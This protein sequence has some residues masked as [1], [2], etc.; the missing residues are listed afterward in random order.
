VILAALLSGDE[1]IRLLYR[2]R[3]N[4]WRIQ[5]DSVLR[6]LIRRTTEAIAQARCWCSFWLSGYFITPELVV[7]ADG[8][9]ISNGSISNSPCR[10]TG[11]GGCI[12]ET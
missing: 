4:P 11:A 2:G 8:T 10:P 3:E 6:A 12:W 5:L 1:T 9:F 7:G